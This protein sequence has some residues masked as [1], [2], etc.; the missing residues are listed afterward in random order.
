M[1]VSGKKEPLDAFEK[2]VSES[3]AFRKITSVVDFVAT[4]FHYAP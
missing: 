2:N 4:L 3:D 1:L